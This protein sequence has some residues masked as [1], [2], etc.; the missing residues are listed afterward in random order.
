[1][2]INR[3]NIKALLGISTSTYDG[4]IDLSL[5]IILSDISDYCKRYFIAKEL[6]FD[7]YEQGTL[8]FET[9]KVT[10]NSDIEFIVGDWFRVFGSKYNDGLYQVKSI[11]GKELTI[12]TSQSFRSETIISYLALVAFPNSFLQIVA[13]YTNKSIINPNNVSKEKIDEVEYTYFKQS[14]IS[15]FLSGNSSLNK[16]R[17]LYKEVFP[18]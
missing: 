15:S 4:K 14:D 1:M 16:Y 3:T 7:I 11:S 5:P 17:L 18:W 10:H 12:E 2:I 6:T 9:T 8:I 13:D